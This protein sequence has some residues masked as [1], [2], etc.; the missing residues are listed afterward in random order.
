MILFSVRLSIHQLKVYTH[1]SRIWYKCPQLLSQ[2]YM[3]LCFQSNI[4]SF[5]ILVSH[6]LS[7][8][9]AFKAFL[10]FYISKIS[11]F[12]LWKLWFSMSTF[13]QYFFHYNHSL[14][15]NV[16]CPLLLKFYKITLHMQIS[17]LINAFT[18]I[19]ILPSIYANTILI[20]N[21][22]RSNPIMENRCVIYMYSW[23]ISIKMVEKTLKCL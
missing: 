15:R 6:E 20:R 14:C 9:W 18:Q 23:S 4:I 7:F 5:I 3:F 16:E 22:I 19:L 10:K 11:N 1:G 21:F 13:Y 12:V 17:K 8:F 2:C